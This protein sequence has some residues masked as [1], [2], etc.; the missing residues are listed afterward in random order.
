MSTMRP[1]VWFTADTHFGHSRI[2]ELS[3][4]P[5]RDVRD[6]DQTLIER[7]NEVVAP[8]DLV[9]HLGD[10][11]YK[12]DPEKLPGIFHR[13]NGVKN[14]VKGNHDHTETMNLPWASISMLTEISVDS[15][16]VVLCHYPLHEWRGYHRGTVHLYGHV[17]GTNPAPGRSCDVGV[18]V[19][20]YRPVGIADILARIEARS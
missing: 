6:Q 19:W 10:F 16:A 14:L 8:D 17:H 12:A 5:F 1:R 3:K 20:A 2:L 7:W 15:E 4:R 13:L 11:A 9:Y 18:D